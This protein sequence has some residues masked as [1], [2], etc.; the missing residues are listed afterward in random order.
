MVI[1]TADLGY[2]HDGTKRRRVHALR[3]RCIPGQLRA[4][5]K[6]ARKS[7]R[8]IRRMDAGTSRDVCS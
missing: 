1:Q 2:S 6:R 3:D 7:R 4:F 8:M 5:R